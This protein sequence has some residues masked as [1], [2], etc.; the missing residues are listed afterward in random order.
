M[1]EA[2]SL[3]KRYGEHTA[4]DDLSFTVRPGVVT[5]F[6]GPNGAGKSTTM[7]MLLGLDAP[8]RAGPRSTAGSTPST[9]H[10][11]TRWARCSKRARVHTGR[12]AY[13]HLLALAATTGISRRRV[14][15]VIDLVGLSAVAGKRVGGFSLGMGQ[16][17]GIAGAAGRPGDG[18]PRRARQRPGPGGDPVDPQ[19]AQRACRRGAHGPGLVT[20][21]VGDGA[22]GRT[23]DRDRAGSTDR[24]HLGGSVRRPGRRRRGARAHRRAGQA[25]RAAGRTGRD[26]RRAGGGRAPGD[27]AEQ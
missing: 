12:S 19:S 8:P 24:G 1:I 23:P 21:D 10:R 11:C 13:H 3:T 5:G 9:G 7:R 22:D 15:E 4:V 17:L 20:P 14:N 25:V 18:D 26:G 2:H 6:L 27:R 16:R